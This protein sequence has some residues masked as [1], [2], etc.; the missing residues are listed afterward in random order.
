VLLWK[1]EKKRQIELKKELKQLKKEAELLQKQAD[2]I[3][4]QT[5]SPL[6]PIGFSDMSR[7]QQGEI[8]SKIPVIH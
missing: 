1:N 7:K 3:S 4:Y 2:V 5:P 6:G 8:P